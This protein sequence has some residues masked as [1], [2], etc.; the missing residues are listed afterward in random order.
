MVRDA[1]SPFTPGRPV[2]VEF[3]VGRQAE[4]E[5]LRQKVRNAV[6]GR[7]IE[8]AFVS[9]ER[10][11]GKSS[12]ASFVRYLCEKDPGTLGIHAFLGGV[13]T[14]QDAVKKVFDGLLKETVETTFFESIKGLFGKHVREVGLFGISVEFAPEEREL[15]TLA[16][17]FAPALQNLLDRLKDKRNGIVLILDDINGLAGSAEFANWF[18]SFV[19]EVSTSQRALPLCVIFV[20]LDERRH[21]LIRV[22][23]SLARVFEPVDIRAW[24]DVESRGFFENAFRKANMR[25]EP[26]ALD[27][28]TRYAGG[29]PVLAHEIGDAAFSANQDDHIG[30]Q[31]AIEGVVAAAEIV[32][33][34]Y[35]DPIVYKSMRSE[36]YRAILRR[37]AK[38]LK[39][40]RFT[41]AELRGSLPEDERGV[42][43][44]F[45]KK[46]KALGVLVEDPAGERGSYRFTN[47]LH[48]LYFSL[49]AEKPDREE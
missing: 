46:M 31:D 37:M 4:I 8:V 27:L 26:E 28:L 18:K 22:Q 44:S 2:P 11:I 5:R 42:F 34:R 9:G 48:H 39:H 40:E 35:L 21:S 47:R 15:K 3:F 7:R 24:S 33:R 36:R 23:P 12:L 25:C 38:E 17:N 10:G 6:G 30:M 1:T 41:R 29:F 20:G 13:D 32:G 14:V 43:D 49:Q 16:N 45:L 19:D